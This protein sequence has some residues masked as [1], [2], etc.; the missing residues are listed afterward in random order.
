[1]NLLAFG[2]NYT[3]PVAVRE[4]LA[5]DEQQ[6]TLALEQFRT[7]P[8]HEAVIL[9]TCNRVEAYVVS[10]GS[11]EDAETLVDFLGTFHGLDCCAI[12]DHP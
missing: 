12:R 8:G 11:G 7:R 6:L 4:R 5:F 9:S 10:P 2:C 1:M 3:T